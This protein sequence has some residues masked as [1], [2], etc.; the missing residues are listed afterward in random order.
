M[1]RCRVI[2]IAMPPGVLMI[3]QSDQYDTIER[4]PNATSRWLSGVCYLQVAR[5][6]CVNEPPGS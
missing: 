5:A 2:G 6:M 1:F 4:M 3:G